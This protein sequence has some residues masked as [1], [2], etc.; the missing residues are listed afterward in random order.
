MYN[1]EIVFQKILTIL[2]KKRIL[3]IVSSKLKRLLHTFCV[4]VKLNF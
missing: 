3:L 4:N 2:A 1:D